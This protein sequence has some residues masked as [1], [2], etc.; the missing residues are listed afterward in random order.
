VELKVARASDHATAVAMLKRNQ[1]NGRKPL[2]FNVWKQV[3]D[4]LGMMRHH[5][6]ML[7]NVSDLGQIKV[8]ERWLEKVGY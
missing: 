1:N 3:R 6:A 8:H 4:C 7:H 2:F 5:S